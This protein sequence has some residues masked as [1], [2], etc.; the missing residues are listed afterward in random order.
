MYEYN[1]FEWKVSH[2]FTPLGIFFQ[3]KKQ[4]YIFIP[5]NFLRC[6]NSKF[7]LLCIFLSHSIYT[8]EYIYIYIV[9][10]STECD[11]TLSTSTEFNSDF[12]WLWKIDYNVIVILKHSSAIMCKCKVKKIV[13]KPLLRQSLYKSNIYAFLVLFQL[14]PKTNFN[15]IFSNV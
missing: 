13:M 10:E 15:L 5:P 8:Y 14:D 1:P 7:K 4:Q 2:N 9:K 3:N 12:K 11:F 6:L